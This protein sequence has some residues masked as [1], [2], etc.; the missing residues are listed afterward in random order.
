[1]SPKP[2]FCPTLGGTWFYLPT[3]LK[4]PLLHLT[5]WVHT[6]VQAHLPST[7]SALALL[8]GPPHPARVS[9]TE[10]GSPVKRHLLISPL[11]GRTTSRV[12]N[13]LDSNLHTLPYQTK[14]P[15]ITYNE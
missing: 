13:S 6:D 14:K 10:T 15:H 12:T 8:R 11:R 3:N 7:P 9:A 2:L 5:A 1:M 4:G